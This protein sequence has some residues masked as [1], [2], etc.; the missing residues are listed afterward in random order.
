M[1][2]GYHHLDQE[3]RCQLYLLKERGDSSATIA[4]QLGVDRFYYSS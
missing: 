4:W 3:Q 1:P 2:Q